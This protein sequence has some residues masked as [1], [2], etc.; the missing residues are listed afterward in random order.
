MNKDIIQEAKKILVV[1]DDQDIRT[2]LVDQL[3]LDGYKVSGVGT[4]REALEEF[5][6]FAP[7][8]V[9]L[10]LSLPDIDGLIICQHLRKRSNVP[11]I[12]LSARES[13][14]DKIR[15]LDIGADDYMTKPFEFLELAA[16]IKAC[17]RRRGKSGRGEKILEAGDITIFPEQ[18]T[19]TVRG[20]QVNLTRKEFELLLAL[21]ENS[22]RVLKRKF[23]CS[24]LW[25]NNEVY[26]W[27]RA[28]DVHVRRLRQKIEPDPANPKYILTHSG[29]GYRF[30][31]E[32]DG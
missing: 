15:G 31:M 1:E 8:L 13:L 26:P 29:V 3:E 12:I 27:S 2:V 9:I 10:D 21:V 11:V 22:N 20:E 6:T 5:I 24:R 19:V 25:K 18:R 28:L 4:G 14:A 16:R 30:S 17:I 32:E 7:D 23:L